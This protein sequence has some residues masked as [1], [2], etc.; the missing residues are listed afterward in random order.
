M[1]PKT[2]MLFSKRHERV[3]LIEKTLKVSLP[4]RLRNRIWQ[5]LS[6]YDF[7]S[8]VVRDPSSSWHENTS[9]LLEVERSLLR[10]YGKKK[11]EAL[12]YK[13]DRSKP[14]DFEG[15]VMGGYP[16]QVLDAIELTY[17][18]LW[19]EYPNSFQQ[20]V[21]Q[22][23]LEERSCWLLCDGYF[24]Q[25]DSSFLEN[26]VLAKTHELLKQTGFEGA[27]DEFL[28][29][30]NDLVSKDCKGAIQNACK[31]FESTLKAIEERTDGN[32]NNLINEL[33]GTDFYRGLP[34][35]F[36]PAFGSAVLMS[37]PFLRN[38]LGGH[39]QGATVIE[40]PETVAELAVNLSASLINFLVTRHL[41]LK[42]PK[43]DP[44]EESIPDD[45]LPF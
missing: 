34:E 17:D 30:R 39:G 23:M 28:A 3:I 19:G 2:R 27:L 35:D 36:G 38:K 18:E 7:A 4:N 33:I 25:I 41:E 6:D 12:D 15:F 29:A 21:N 22:V 45:D 43:P 31:A 5:V 16:S 13:E 9:V 14:T 1:T 44:P 10:T 8:Q 37:L 11:L 24:F 32:S 40:V 20:A 26:H 42:P